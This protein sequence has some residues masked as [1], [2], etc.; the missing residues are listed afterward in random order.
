MDAGRGRFAQA[1]FKVQGFDLD[2]RQLPLAEGLVLG[3]KAGM[4]R[5]A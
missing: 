2:E 1:G 5:R 3:M 4:E